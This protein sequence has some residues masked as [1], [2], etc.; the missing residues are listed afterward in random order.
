MQT[1]NVI[2]LFAIAAVAALVAAWL[3]ALAG[4]GGQIDSLFRASAPMTPPARR[5]ATSI[6]APPVPIP[7]QR[8]ENLETI[9]PDLDL[10]EDGTLES[11][12]GPIDAAVFAELLETGLLEESGDPAAAEQLR[13]A[14][15]NA[16]TAQADAP[17]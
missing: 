15:R 3:Y 7:E 5:E 9:P 14:L 10:V 13:E 16:E 8:A 12:T 11:E 2:G 1:R 6:E 4:A 17:E